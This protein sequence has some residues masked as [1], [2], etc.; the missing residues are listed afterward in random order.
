[1]PAWAANHAAQL[2]LHPPGAVE[3][4]SLLAVITIA[5]FL[6]TYLSERRGPDSIW[7][8]LTFGYIVA[9]LANVFAPHLP[10]TLMYRSYTPGVVTAVLVNLPVMSILALRSLRE[11]WV[12]GWKAAAFAVGV[13]LL[14][15]GSILA[16][17]VIGGMI[18]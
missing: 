12:S 6:F 7:A 16:V 17:F 8:Y 14:L 9:M 4:R 3:F 15:S 5:A 10:A 1:M 13:P 2:P 11:G 18:L